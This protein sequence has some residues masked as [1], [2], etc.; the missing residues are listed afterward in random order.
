M[1]PFA[2]L[3]AQTAVPSIPV[4]AGEKIFTRSCAVGYC[5]GIAGAAN[6]GPRLRGRSFDPRYLARVIRM[7]IPNSAMPAFEGK[8]KEEEL[9]AVTA[10]VMSL[11][12]GSGT[13]ASGPPRETGSV[14]RPSVPKKLQAGR[15]LF[16]DATR[17]TR[18]G[19][20][21]VAEG[22]G[23]ETGPDP[24]SGAR[25]HPKDLARVF[26][27]Q[28]PTRVRRAK[29]RDGETFPALI[30][31]N[32]NQITRLLDLTSPPPVLRTLEPDDIVSLETE[33][34]WNHK[35]AIAG[36][37]DSELSEISRYLLWLAAAR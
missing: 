1:F 37:S 18:C 29:L 5:H 35:Q 32:E 10:Y 20:C 22:M 11:S 3:L 34:D 2:L 24:V 12:P 27:S 16:F 26:R 30:V 33:R 14:S 23:L 13:P 31:S 19:T 21:H 15:D 9:T 36:Y 8:L 17:A 6:R 7:G 28:Q 4:A 25:Q